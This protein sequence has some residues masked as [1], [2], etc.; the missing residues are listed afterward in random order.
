MFATTL[1]LPVFGGVNLRASSL[2]ISTFARAG[3]LFSFGIKS[4]SISIAVV[5]AVCFASSSVSMPR[6]GPISI[7]WSFFVTFAVLTIR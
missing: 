4:E 5:W 7:I 3:L 6:P 2:R 1:Y